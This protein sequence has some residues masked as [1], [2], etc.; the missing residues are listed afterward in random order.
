MKIVG[1]KSAISSA[2]T[3]VPEPVRSK[4][5]IVSAIAAAHD[6]E[7]AAEPLTGG[8]LRIEVGFPSV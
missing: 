8:G 4:T 1:R 2:L 5:S 3:Q 6:A 7:L